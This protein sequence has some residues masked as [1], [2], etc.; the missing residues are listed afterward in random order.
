MSPSAPPMA[1]NENCKKVSPSM[2]PSAPPMAYNENC[3]NIPMLFASRLANER[4][5]SL[6]VYFHVRA[7][8][9]PGTQFQCNSLA[10]K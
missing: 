9:S 4:L 1:Y 5:N 7:S 2:S 10:F 8:L 3:K 6:R